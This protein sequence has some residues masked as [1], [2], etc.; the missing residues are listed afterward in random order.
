MNNILAKTRKIFITILSI[1][2]ILGILSSAFG[3]SVVALTKVSDVIQVKKEAEN[4]DENK[5]DN[6]LPENKQ[7]KLKNEATLSKNIIIL[8][9]AVSDDINKSIKKIERQRSYDKNL[10]KLILEGKDHNFTDHFNEGDTVYI[11]S[12]TDSALGGDKIIIVDEIYE[13]SDETIIEGYEPPVEEV[14]SDI[15]ISISDYLTEENLIN[16]DYA[17]GVSSHFGKIEDELANADIPSEDTQKDGLIFDIDYKYGSNK[18]ENADNSSYNIE[19]QFAVKDL[20][21]NV[22]IDMESN[23]TI[24]DF[25]IGA[26]GEVFTDLEINS[27]ISNSE[28]LEAIKLDEKLNSYDA[29]SDRAFPLAALEFHGDTQIKFNDDDFSSG[30]KALS[31][32]FV[33]FIY[34]DWDNRIKLTLSSSFEIADSFNCGLN[35]YADGQEDLAF[36]EFAHTE[37]YDIDDDLAWETDIDINA[38]YDVTL[39][40]GSVICYVAGINLGE[41]SL[42]RIGIEAYDEIT[43]IT[44]TGNMD[45]YYSADYSGAYIRAYVRMMEINLALVRDN[46]E[47]LKDLNDYKYFD[48]CLDNIVLAEYGSIPTRYKDTAPVSS[49]K[50]PQD[51]DTVTTLVFDL[52]TSMNESANNNQDKL[53]AA[54]DAA[55]TI[56]STTENWSEKYE[57]NDGIGVVY[58]SDYSDILSEPHTDY[59]YINSVIDSMDTIGGTYIHTGI[60]NAIVQLNAITCESKSVILLTDGWDHDSSTTI[61]SAKEA[62]KYNIKI[63]TIG[64]GNSNSDVDEDLLKEIAQITGGEYRFASTDDMLGITSSFMYAQQASNAEV[65]TDINGAV[66]EGETSDKTKFSVDPKNGDLIVTTLWPG[67]FLDTILV[68]PNGRI[69][70]ENYPGAVTDESQIPSTIT[71]E[72]PLEGDWSVCVKGVETSYEE[73]PFYTIVAFKETEDRKINS[74]M[75]PLQLLAAYCIP[76]GLFATISSIMLLCCCKKKK[77]KTE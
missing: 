29:V 5:D 32:T 1:T 23:K 67:S 59:D 53:A 52:S 46:H 35:V 39:F 40:G 26:S 71:V 25:Y 20:A 21:A 42:T 54:K 11:E 68:D 7:K 28:T 47:C 69:V 3:I 16:A 8:P 60:D 9:E 63:F 75:T 57:T 18:T 31:P 14:F 65:L 34:A 33:V 6:E 48:F 41:L 50:P 51:F 73:E 22:I 13:N 45:D 49:S 74:E 56:V 64:F 70:D 61:E 38:S 19:G 44:S 77:S 37:N 76:I 4:K 55:K 12:D 24:N 27:N 30:Q 58:F 72:N 15:E 2:L 36:E 66:K 17:N 10:I 62:A 43:A